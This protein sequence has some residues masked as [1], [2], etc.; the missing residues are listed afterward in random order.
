MGSLNSQG[1]GNYSVHLGIGKAH[2]LLQQHGLQ[3]GIF[4]AQL[5]QLCT[6][7]CIT[8]VAGSTVNTVGAMSC[9]LHMCTNA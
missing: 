1:S 9:C 2:P 6:S 8:A 7:I 4:L 3:H 5:L